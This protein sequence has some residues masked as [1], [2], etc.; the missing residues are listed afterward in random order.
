[1]SKTALAFKKDNYSAFKMKKIAEKLNDLACPQ[2]KKKIG[3]V[4]LKGQKE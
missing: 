2:E 4:R 3:H 1:M